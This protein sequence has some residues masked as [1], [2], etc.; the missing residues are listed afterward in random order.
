M[1]KITETMSI[2]E[3]LEQYPQT[4]EVF[5]RYGLRPDKYQAMNYENLHASAKV[6]QLSVETLLAEL[7]QRI[8]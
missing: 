5:E 8:Q 4:R 7:N 6:H 1:S 2:P 3:I